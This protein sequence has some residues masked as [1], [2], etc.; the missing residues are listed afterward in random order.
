MPGQPC[1]TCMPV[2]S[3]APRVHVVKCSTT[4][5]ASLLIPSPRYLWHH[6]AMPNDSHAP[7]R[8]FRTHSR[9][10][11]SYG[12]GRSR[13][14]LR[15]LGPHACHALATGGMQA[16]ATPC[17][18]RCIPTGRARRYRRTQPRHRERLIWSLAVVYF[19]NLMPSIRD[20][21]H[22]QCACIACVA[23]QGLESSTE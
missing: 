15:W 18:D 21:H 11:D 19:M 5:F 12:P 20:S 14:F 6:A 7:Y 17:V 1:G 4:G 16:A 10:R 23:S 8:K 2:E 9:H 3:A 13:S 22:V